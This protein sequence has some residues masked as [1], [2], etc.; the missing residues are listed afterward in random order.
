MTQRI[1][2][3]IRILLIFFG[4]YFLLLSFLVIYLEKYKNEFWQ[5]IKT[6]LETATKSQI[7]IS[8]IEFDLIKSYPNIRFGF[9]DFEII[10]STSKEKVVSA[11]KIEAKIDLFSILFLNPEITKIYVNNALVQI[12]NNASGTSNFSILNTKNDNGIL[13]QTAPKPFS[14]PSYLPI[15]EIQLSNFRIKFV[16]S[17]QFK[18]IDLELINHKIL[19]N[20]QKKSISINGKTHFG[21]LGFNTKFGYFLQNAD[22][23]TN[24]NLQ[25][26]DSLKRFTIF[27]SKAMLDT[28][29]L[30]IS[31]YILPSPFDMNLIIATKA[32]LPH[33]VIPYLNNNIQNILGNIIVQNP[34]AAS[35]TISGPFLPKIDPSIHLVFSSENNSVGYK[36]LPFA[37]NKMAFNGYFI[38]RIDTNKLP[39]D[40]NSI[41][42][43]PE[44]KGEI[45]FSK[46]SAYAKIEN[47]FYPTLQAKT[48]VYIDLPTLEKNIKG[49][50]LSNAQ[51]NAHLTLLFNGNLP[52]FYGKFNFA[53]WK[54]KG[55]CSFNN[56][57]FTNENIEYKNINGAFD[58][59][60]DT[61]RIINALKANIAGNQVEVDGKITR[62]IFH[63]LSKDSLMEAF[64]KIKSENFDI[65]NLIK[66]NID[67]TT[68]KKKSIKPR[69]TIQ[70]V[71]ESLRNIKFNIDFYLK[72]AKYKK[73]ET[74]N[75]SGTLIHYGDKIELKNLKTDNPKGK[76][77]LKFLLENLYENQKKISVKMSIKK[78]DVN[79][80]FY[81]MNNFDQKTIVAQNIRGKINADISIQCSL[82]KNYEIIRKTINADTKLN[83]EKGKLIDF[84]PLTHITK[85][86]FSSKRTDTISFLSITQK[87]KIKNGNLYIEDMRIETNIFSFNLKGDFN[88]QNDANLK[89]NI[90]WYNLKTEKKYKEAIKNKNKS[91]KGLVLRFQMTSGKIKVSPLFN[92]R[93]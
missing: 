35:V 75:I 28:A 81:G 37:V 25:Y 51:G 12:K 74:T 41:I 45:G 62:P 15:H 89:I 71:Q 6:E 88:E 67:K 13:N 91:E 68:I 53:N 64:F 70:K 86:I 20:T 73:L 66:G 11:G 58:V 26:I 43:I 7:H 16:D 82:N 59:K 93:Y 34:V 21:G 33:I 77:N 10:D 76:I 56:I 80:F 14:F 61:F 79:H 54:Y 36:D 50:P 40:Q 49:F 31:G 44:I 38:N 29:T 84:K 55:H 48:S 60:N 47:L 22:L 30:A 65:N 87:S 46:V 9:N 72:K 52:D 90:P 83:I 63:I 19:I 1:K 4:C 2:I 69:E 3:F 32:I 17:S 24:I 39:G 92:E 8:S 23:N 42:N 78:F 18:Y 57:N 85:Y 5:K 27:E